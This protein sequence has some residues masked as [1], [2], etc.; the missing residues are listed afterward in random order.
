MALLFFPLNKEIGIKRFT[1]TTI[2]SKKK[3]FYYFKPPMEFSV[4]LA[5]DDFVTVC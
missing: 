3:E 1:S 2:C 4:K 5:T